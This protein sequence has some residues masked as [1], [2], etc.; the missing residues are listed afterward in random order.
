VKIFVTGGTGFVGSHLVSTLLGAGH[1][2]TCLVRN[3]AKAA[4]RFGDRLPALIEGGLTDS[5]AIERGC[6]GADAIFHVAGLVAAPTAADLHRINAEATGRLCGIARERAPGLAH[7]VYVSSLAAAGPTAPGAPIREDRR[8]QPVSAYGRS[9]LAGEALVR[10]SGLPWTVVRPPTVYGPWDRELLKV[11]RL[12]RRGVVPV[13]GDGA[14][15]NSLIYAPDLAEALASCLVP[16]AVGR[17]YFAA[18]PEIVTQREL[19]ERIHRTV[20]GEG[21]APRIVRIPAP[22][23]RA[24]LSIIGTVAAL[25]RTPTLLSRDKANEFLADA[26]TCRP[27]ALRVD[28]GWRAGTDLTAGL[29]RTAAWYR[30]RQWL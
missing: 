29:R 12:A 27:D 19:S 10:E 5:P 2:V 25:T 20:R 21:T 26:W 18:H 16:A 11:F 28:T 1:D 8:P 23:A 30:D 7:F 9:K 15:E 6:G 13:F 24:V 3:P 14:Q 22:L 4:R 17:T